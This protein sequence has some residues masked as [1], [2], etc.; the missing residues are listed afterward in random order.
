MEKRLLITIALSILVV[1]VW[2][3]L[4]PKP[5]PIADKGVIAQAVLQKEAEQ[6]STQAVAAQE[7][8]AP[9]VLA[10]F[11]NS[12]LEVDFIEST[13]AIKQV[14]FK[15]YKNTPFMLRRGFALGDKSLVFSKSDSTPESITFVHKDREKI[16]SKK[17]IF[18]NSNYAIDLE[19][20][21]KN[22]TSLPILLGTPV[23]LGVLDYSQAGPDSSF[24]D[25][26]IS[27]AE[28]TKHYNPRK[29]VSIPAVKFIG[30]RDKYFCAILEAGV[31]SQSGFINKLPDN[32]SEIGITSKE[33]QVPANVQIGHLYHLYLGP[34]RIELINQ[35]KPE[36]ASIINY[37]TFDFIAQILLM[38]LEF[39]YKLVHSWGWTIVI[40]SFAVYF[41]LYPLSIKQMRS[42]KEMQV[43]QPK[44]EALRK[45]Y[46]DNPQRLNKEIMEL[47][48]EHKVNPFSGCLPLLLQMPIFFALYQVLM[49]S[50]VLKGTS[51]LWIKDL[52][53]PD[54][55]VTFSQ[56]LPIV[57]SEINILPI[58]MAIGM[59]VQQKL[60]VVSADSSTAEQQKI[61]TL[62]FPLMF[63]VLFYRMPSG[64]V[65]YWLINSTLM[66]IMQLRSRRT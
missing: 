34:Q 31:A 61:M 26:A 20:T 39:I 23:I 47:Y 15:N 36:W 59:F 24:E 19:V 22:L 65:I 32:K 51:F 11:A 64:L 60:T 42:M 18:S 50:V 12:R 2:S 44:I 41:L 4:S 17:Y 25:V 37:G 46:K 14:R 33:V 54:R 66:L 13:A 27:S 3:T 45:N 63:G 6:A 5:Q 9:E 1:T 35:V 28:K 56:K 29:G 38:L 40:F 8:I 53:L 52:S 55:L 43:L 58:L 62:V 10:T 49:R 21:V 7:Q 16:V 57:G 48:K 30:L